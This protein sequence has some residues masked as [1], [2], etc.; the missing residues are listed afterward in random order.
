MGETAKVSGSTVEFFKGVDAYFAV[1]MAHLSVAQ[2]DEVRRL[3]VD[4]E[5]TQAGLTGIVGNTEFFSTVS[6][7]ELW[8]F[9]EAMQAGA[10]GIDDEIN[11]TVLAMLCLRLLQDTNQDIRQFFMESM[12]L[13][14]DGILELAHL[15][16]TTSKNAAQAGY[17]SAIITAAAGL[18]GGVMQVGTSV[19]GGYNLQSIKTQLGDV[20]RLE[21]ANQGLRSDIERLGRPEPAEKAAAAA[22]KLAQKNMDADPTNQ[23][24]I[25]AKDTA[26]QERLDLRTRR[27]QE[28]A[29]AEQKLKENQQ[30]IDRIKVRMDAGTNWAGLWTRSGQAISATVN[31]AAGMPAAVEEKVSK[32]TAALAQFYGTQG[33]TER[34]DYDFLNG[35]SQT[36]DGNFRQGNDTISAVISAAASSNSATANRMA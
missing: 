31:S 19:G 2:A 10:A 29:E 24:H 32:E 18:V 12:F 16:M 21:A 4:G 20:K 3:A 6:M 13:T 11:P 26:R 27:H 23:A 30:E 33:S 5:L 22:Q 1:D 7:E 15:E 9:P 28:K 17:N 35:M 36:A 34:A 8:Q 14:Q 25:A